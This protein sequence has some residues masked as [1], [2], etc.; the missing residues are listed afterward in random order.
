MVLKLIKF[1]RI[2]FQ[3]NPTVIIQREIFNE[4]DVNNTVIHHFKFVSYYFIKIITIQY[5][6]SIT[7]YRMIIRVSMYYVPIDF[8]LNNLTTY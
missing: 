5:K 2:I 4:I 6:F 1:I 3:V 8:V 7:F